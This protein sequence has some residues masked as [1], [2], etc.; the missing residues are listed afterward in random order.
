MLLDKFPM[1]LQRVFSPETHHFEA[2]ESA[3]KRVARESVGTDFSRVRK[4]AG[5][6]GL[7]K[8]FQ[9]LVVMGA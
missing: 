9:G 7:V 5:E 3:Q 1:R 4:V 2:M 6:R 8:C